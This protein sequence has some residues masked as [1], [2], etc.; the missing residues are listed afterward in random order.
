MAKKK[1]LLN[2]VAAKPK[3][4]SLPEKDIKVAEIRTSLIETTTVK[5]K[6]PTVSKKKSK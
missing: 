3:P 2:K 4:E 1:I 6:K 5:S